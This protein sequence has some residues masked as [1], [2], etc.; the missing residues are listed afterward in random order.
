V[1]QR[2]VATA[3]A[4]G[5]LVG[6]PGSFLEPA[7]AFAREARRA[8]TRRAYKPAYRA[9]AT[10]RLGG[11]PLDVDTSTATS[12]SPTATTSAPPAPL[13]RRSAPRYGRRAASPRRSS[14]TRGSRA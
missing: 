3:A 9:F 14:S 6:A 2:A 8:N 11:H 13:L 7:L 5:E 4:A 10:A 12:S 1:T